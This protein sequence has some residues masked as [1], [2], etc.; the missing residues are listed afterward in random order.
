MYKNNDW[1][2]VVFL[3]EGRP[4]KGTI[5]NL[6]NALATRSTHQ[7]ND[8]TLS[9]AFWDDTS[10]INRKD[11][12]VE[13]AAD[14]VTSYQV[15]IITISFEG[16]E[17]QV[18]CEYNDN[19]LDSVPHLAFSEQIHP[20]TETNETRIDAEIKRRRHMFAGILADAGEIV[21]PKWG[22]GRRGGVASDSEPAIELLTKNRPPL[23]EY[24]LFN[25]EMVDFIGHEAIIDSP[26]WYVNELSSGGVFLIT[27]E[28]PRSCS[29]REDACV[30]VV[31]HLGLNMAD[32]Y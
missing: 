30:A 14:I 31:R 11:V 10:D 32:F 4:T 24:N 2:E 9:I 23:Y 22:F 7:N 15:S 8:E 28:P 6:L 12:G 25:S 5:T 16:F 18:G 20:F 29:P 17:L 1:I 13:G 26:A 3:F 21:T 19:Y 27:R